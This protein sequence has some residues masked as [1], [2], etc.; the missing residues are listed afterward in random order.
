MGVKEKKRGPEK[1]KK[2]STY[3]PLIGCLAVMS[4]VSG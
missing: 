3:Q 4:Y 1:E 2:K